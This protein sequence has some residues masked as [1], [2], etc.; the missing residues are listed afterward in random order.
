MVTTPDARMRTLSRPLLTCLLLL[1]LSLL[2]GCK[3]FTAQAPNGFAT[4]DKGGAF[5]AVSPDGVIYRVRD[6]KNKPQAELAFWKEALKKRML[7]AGYRFVAESD[8]KAGDASGYLLELNA[9]QGS[10]DYTYLTA[11]FVEGDRLVIVESAGEVTRFKARR[12]VVMEAIG[13]IT[14]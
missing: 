3:S 9:P 14:F 6:E 7:D 11:L 8:V 13:K 1:L 2:G 4:Y 5:R 10:Q 12:D